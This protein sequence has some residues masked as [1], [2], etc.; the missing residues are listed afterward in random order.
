MLLIN[1][2]TEKFAALV[3]LIEMRFSECNLSEYLYYRDC[4]LHCPVQNQLLYFINS[5]LMLLVWQQEGHSACKKLRGEV[6][7][8]LSV[9]SEVQTCIWPS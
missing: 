8:L 5:A 6:L 3:A 2:I 1:V 4:R 9:W 7:A